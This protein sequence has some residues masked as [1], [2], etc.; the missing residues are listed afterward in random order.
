M[1]DSFV[2]HYNFLSDFFF[3]TAQITLGGFEI[4]NGPQKNWP[5]LM[6]I[7]TPIGCRSLVKLIFTN[8]Y[9]FI[10][11]YRSVL[12]VI[13][14]IIVDHLSQTLWRHIRKGS[15]FLKCLDFPKVGPLTFSRS[16]LALQENPGFIIKKSFAASL[17]GS[18]VI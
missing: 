1:C 5:L 12:K 14:L 9:T 18:W 7:F 8:I 17:L 2:I 3:S 4:I 16:S 13:I 10:T 11:S 15:I 6:R